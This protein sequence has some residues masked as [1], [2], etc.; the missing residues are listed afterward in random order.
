MAKKPSETRELLN[1]NYFWLGQYQVRNPRYIALDNE[2]AQ[3]EDIFKRFDSRTVGFEDQYAIYDLWGED[4][5]F[6]SAPVESYETFPAELVK[7]ALRSREVT[8]E[9]KK[10]FPFAC[11]YIDPIEIY[12][13]E[14]NNSFPPIL[15]WESQKSFVQD[16]IPKVHVPF[17]FEDKD[18]NILHFEVDC[19]EPTSAIIDTIR[20]RIEQYKEYLKNPDPDHLFEKDPSLPRHEDLLQECLVVE[21]E[22]S[23]GFQLR[24]NVNEPRAVG[25][26][27]YDYRVA[28]GSSSNLREIFDAA[29]GE[30]VSRAG[31]RGAPRVRKGDDR[32]KD[33]YDW[34][35][36][37]ERCVEAGKVLKIKG[38]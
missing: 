5:L 10:N 8:Q 23:L 13:S 34:L 24:D 33:W 7:L 31:R 16:Y 21:V 29:Y 2:L 25:L 27:A 14:K 20:L 17:T 4:I 3:I 28:K 32:Y 12:I 38:K 9:I 22:N 37:A 19:T 30:I 1:R 26:L 15:S 6:S 11:E 18:K 36:N 35:K